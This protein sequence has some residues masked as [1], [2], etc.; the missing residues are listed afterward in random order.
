MKTISLEFN[1][2]WREVNKASVPSKPGI[3][4]VYTCTYNKDEKTVSLNR[5]VYVG[6]S[7][8][9][10]NRIDSHERLEDWKKQLKPGETLCYSIA[11]KSGDDRNRAEAAV[12]YHHKPPCNVEY[13]NS[14]PF[15][16]TTINTSGRNAKLSSCFVV[17]DTR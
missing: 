1:G 12:I 2:Y 10:H 3:Y 8:N 15:P 7:E 6:E 16:D 17:H 13:V 11:E 4:C 5:L 14:F 9:V